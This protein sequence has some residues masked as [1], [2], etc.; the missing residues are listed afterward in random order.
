M[1]PPRAYYLTTIISIYM[2]LSRTERVVAITQAAV[3]GLGMS[4]TDE[5][6]EE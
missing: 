2:I 5:V 4:T 6:E 3:T 1:P